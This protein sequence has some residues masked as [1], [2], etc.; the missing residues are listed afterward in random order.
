ML[1]F[2]AYVCIGLLFWK[3]IRI[4]DAQR[5]FDDRLMLVQGRCASLENEV[6]ATRRAPVAEPPSEPAPA[7]PPPAPEPEPVLA[8]PPP[9]PVAAPAPPPLPAFAPPPVRQPAPPL[10]Q[11]PSGGW[12]ELIGGNLLNKLGALVLVIGIALFL[13][14]SFREMEASGRAFTGL[15]VSIAILGG[16]LWLERKPLYKTYSYGLIAAGWGALYFT[17]YAM[18]AL[19]AARVI[20]NPGIGVAAMLL[21]AIPMVLHSLKYKVEALTA[22]TYGTVFAALALSSRNAFVAVALIPLA[23]SIL[24]VARR[25]QWYGVAVFGAAATYTTFLTRPNEGSPLWLIQFLLALYWVM[26]ETFDIM[27]VHARSEDTIWTRGLFWLN[28][29]AG[30]GAS[31]S[32]WYRMAPDSMW[33]FSAGAAV[34]YLGSTWA[35][36]VIDR[37]SRY[38]FALMLSSLLAGLAIFARAPGM[39]SSMGLLLEAETLFLAGLYF[40]VRLGQA[41]GWLGFAATFLKIAGNSGSAQSLL[42]GW[43]IDYWA[44]PL[45]VMAIVFY[46]NRHLANQRVFS[47]LGS[48]FVWFIIGGE[49]EQ[50][51]I[52]GAWLVLAAVLFEAGLR[53]GLFDY[54]IQAYAIGFTGTIALAM[55]PPGTH[56][57]WPLILGTTATLGA[58]IRAV[59]WM[60]SLGETERFCIRTGGSLAA[61]LITG[62][63]AARLASEPYWGLAIVG[64]ALV[65]LDLAFRKLPEEMLVPACGLGLVGL[66]TIVFGSGTFEKYPEPAVWISYVGAALAGAYL[67][68]RLF[69]APEPLR[70]VRLLAPWLGSA[71]AAASLWLLLPDPFVPAA[72][73]LL[74]LLI[75]EAGAFFGA[76]DLVWLGRAVT[77][78]AMRS[79]Y[80]LDL[81]TQSAIVTNT[82]ALAAAHWWLWYRT[83]KDEFAAAHGWIAALLIGILIPWQFEPHVLAYWSLL[84]AALAA[85][86]RYLGLQ[87]LR[88]QAAAAALA[89]SL[90]SIVRDAPLWQ[91]VAAAGFLALALLLE[92]RDEP[93]EFLRKGYSAALALVTAFML[94]DQVSGRML[95]VSW[96]IEGFV[97]LAAGFALRERALRLAGLSLL[98]VCIGKVFFYDLRNLETI[99]RILSFIGLGAVLLVVSWIYTRFR[100]QLQ[101]YL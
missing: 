91:D 74:A 87:H 80:G 73:G 96:T 72:T 39:W 32:V 93:G 29:V 35:R 36:F 45:A 79:L 90:V 8:A 84:G 13:S 28:A 82:G 100:E 71:F 34:L 26:F 46:A 10:I 60:P 3:I 40:R 11:K 48:L 25:F 30:L 42:F 24:Y 89:V 77:L 2:L 12:E 68:A 49:F 62:L 75:A 9:L 61:A 6:R 88:W 18:H 47:Y 33:Q 5:A 14:Y 55:F 76:E 101:K 22:L 63:L 78:P 21:V 85:G 53:R 58:A 27:R 64:C 97:L 52:G 50:R 86:W 23:T 19:D 56:Y 92:K 70:Y 54:R 20:A 1:L 16:G 31:A 94:L 59:R 95:T 98:L 17:T 67:T 15:G 4:L 41:L 7:A 37:D 83:R 66:S 38:E 81:G 69:R 99:Y 51:F 43:T 65:L 44:P 57:V